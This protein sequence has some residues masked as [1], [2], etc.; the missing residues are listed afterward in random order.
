M[1]GHHHEHAHSHEH[2][3]H[4]HESARRSGSVLHIDPVAGASGD[5]FLGALVHLG[6]PL[7]VLQEGLNKLAIESL[8]LTA[9]S[10]MRHSIACTKVD[11]VVDD[12]PQPHR[13]LND[14]LSMIDAAEIP[15]R[16]K[17]RSAAALRLLAEAE[18]QAHNMPVEK[19]HLHEVGGL[20]CLADVVGTCLAI[21]HLN[22][23]DIVS[24]P[25]SVGTGHVACAHG[26]MPL[27]AP[28]TLAILQNF[29]I[30]KT[31]FEGE[32]TTPTGAAL[33]ASLAKPLTEPTVY[34]PEKIGYGAGTKDKP[35]IANMLRLVLG[36][37]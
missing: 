24:G 30:R 23:D 22:P 9:H 7:D 19:V 5:M 18:S 13:H 11:V 36:K 1:S 15:E 3:G 8:R 16:V 6:V 32:M 34:Q 17:Q 29:P 2:G 14:L 12:A 37:R 33:I 27:P 20:D 31:N 25:V 35:Q 28:G 4:S 26:L 10:T 21:E